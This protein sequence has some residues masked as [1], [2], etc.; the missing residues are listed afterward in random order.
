MGS[1]ENSVIQ[2]CEQI[3]AREQMPGPPLFRQRLLPHR[4]LVGILFFLS[5]LSETFVFTRS[6]WP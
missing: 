3:F 1:I 2:E 6:R 5:L 4:W